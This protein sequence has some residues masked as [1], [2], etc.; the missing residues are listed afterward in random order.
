VVAITDVAADAYAT[1]EIGP[2]DPDAGAWDPAATLVS[3]L[4]VV[5]GAA[6][7]AFATPLDTFQK[8]RQE[9][10]PSESA[11]VMQWAALFAPCLLNVVFFCG[12]K[13][14]AIAEFADTVGPALLTLCGRFALAVGLV[15]TLGERDSDDPEAALHQAIGII[16]PFPVA[17]KVLL[18]PKN[19]VATTI[20][21]VIDG[22]C[23]M[24]TG[25]LI[26]AAGDVSAQRRRLGAGL[27]TAATA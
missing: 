9:W 23:D 17:A 4:S 18:M 21:V 11:V 22:V 7:Q 19:S 2:F 13:K 20:L 25:A 5:S 15:E 27:G 6:A 3:V 10:S 12:T 24:A 16:G 1:E 14:K 8:S 26:L